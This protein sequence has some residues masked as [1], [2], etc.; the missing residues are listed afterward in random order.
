[1]TLSGNPDDLKGAWAAIDGTDP[2][3]TEIAAE[4]ASTMGLNPVKISAKNRAKYH[5]AAAI[6]SNFLIA[7]EAS[8]ERVAEAAGLPRAALVPLVSQTVANWAE[9][10]ARESLTGPIARGDVETVARHRTAVE[11]CAP[12][13][14]E[15]FDALRAATENLSNEVART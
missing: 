2:E 9:Q 3:C 11:S 10:G 14:L 13:L 15:L 8:A 12:D 1:M 5:A 6:A 4:L 7:L